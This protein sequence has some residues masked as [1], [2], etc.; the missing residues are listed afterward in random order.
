MSILFKEKER[1]GERVLHGEAGSADQGY[2]EIAE[3][4]LPKLLQG[5][6]L[7]DVYNM[8]ET[9]LTYRS[10]LKRTLGSQPRKGI[11]EAKDRICNP[12]WA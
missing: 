4:G 3:A 9:G 7:N 5:V 6:D 12:A 2:I 1:F 11:K 10:I 8:D